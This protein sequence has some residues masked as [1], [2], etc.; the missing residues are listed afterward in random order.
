MHDRALCSEIVGCAC[1]CDRCGVEHDRFLTDADRAGIRALIA[2]DDAAGRLTRLRENE[3][4]LSG[5]LR[6]VA[7]GRLAGVIQRAR[8]LVLVLDQKRCW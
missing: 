6:D 2:N 3:A 8:A 4:A 5:L 7:R 1:P